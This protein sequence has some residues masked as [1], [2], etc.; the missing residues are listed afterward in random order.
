MRAQQGHPA[1]SP[2][3]A[4][5]SLPSEPQLSRHPPCKVSSI[6]ERPSLKGS[7]QGRRHHAPR[8]PQRSP[9]GVAADRNTPLGT[10][11]GIRS[12][13]ATIPALTTTQPSDSG[14]G[15]F[16]FPGPF[17]LL[18]PS[19]PTW[20]HPGPV[21][22]RR[23][24]L[25]PGKAASLGPQTQSRL[26]PPNGLPRQGLCTRLPLSPGPQ[27]ASPRIPGACQAGPGSQLL[28][29]KLLPHPE[30]AMS[31]QFIKFATAPSIPD[32]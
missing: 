14:Y 11:I 20:K 2:F 6:K 12:A 8:G 1:L 28:G 26:T 31:N 19:P 7:G 30:A 13:W 10:E 24:P 17:P 29:R 32:P 5:G 16:T 18:K 15:L 27:P 4:W 22:G 21:A 9:P 3:R 23:H 25:L